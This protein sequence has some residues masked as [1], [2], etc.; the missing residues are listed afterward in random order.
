MEYD[1]QAHCVYYIRYHIVISTKYRR[2][3]INDGVREYLLKQMQEI[4]K[5]YPEIRFEKV[6]GDRD[7]VHILV[8]VPPKTSVSQFVNI[9]KVNVARGLKDK[10][11]FLKKVYWGSE[12]IWST[13]Y[14]V[15][16]VGINESVIRKYIEHQ[17]KED[18]GRAKLELG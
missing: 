18:T 11:A 8:S 5:H 7:H 17:S 6:S 14:F 2:K 9:F 10:F 13:G 4:R 16:T 1:K 3:V 12:S 15:S